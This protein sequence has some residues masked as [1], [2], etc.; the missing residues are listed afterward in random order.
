MVWYL[1]A[2]VFFFYCLTPKTFHYI[3]DSTVT[4]LNSFLFIQRSSKVNNLPLYLFCL[5]PVCLPSKA[6][7]K[8]L[9]VLQCSRIKT[10]C[11]QSARFL[12]YFSVTEKIS[13]QHNVLCVCNELQLYYRF[14]WWGVCVLW[15]CTKNCQN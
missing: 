13:V 8:I 6:D 12:P 7:P 14:Q 15:V 10:T 1:Q 5:H 2:K 9:L 4:S 3:G 11:V